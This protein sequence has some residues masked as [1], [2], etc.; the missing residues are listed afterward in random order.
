MVSSLRAVWVWPSTLVLVASHCSWFRS[1]AADGVR[2]LQVPF[3][4]LF[5]GRPREF[6]FASSSQALF[7]GPHMFCVCVAHRL[8]T[9]AAARPC[10]PL[11]RPQRSPWLLAPFPYG[12]GWLFGEIPRGD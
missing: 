12:D 5:R 1:I 4:V 11:G 8:D 10:R 9:G 2:I 7:L 6:C 3:L